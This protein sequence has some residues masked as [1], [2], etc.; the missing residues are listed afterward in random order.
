MASAPYIS[1]L[2]GRGQITALSRRS[3]PTRRAR[4]AAAFLWH[5]MPEV[6][7]AASVVPILEEL[8]F[9]GFFLGVLLRNFSRLSAVL[10]TSALFA[11]VH[12]LKAPELT[13]PND[14]VT[15]TSGFVSIAHSFGQF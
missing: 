10:I 12:F 1:I 9:R 13:T 4:S 3:R 5:K 8:L 15:W 6:L 7:F 11:V 2:E 14:T